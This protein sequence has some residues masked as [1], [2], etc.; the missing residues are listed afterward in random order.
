MSG[1]EGLV[2]QL[3]A[4]EI[5]HAKVGAFDIDGLLRGKYISLDKLRSALGGG[6]GFCDVIFG[7][8]IVDA[9]YDKAS[10]TGWHRG[11]PDVQAVLDPETVRDVPWE[12]GVAL[13]LADL[14]A[15]DGS[16]HPACPR[17]LLKTIRDRARA[18]G[19]EALFS[20]EFEFFMFKESPHTLQDKDFRGLTPLSPGMFGYS[21]VRS[22]QHSELMTDILAC[23]DAF[24]IEIEGLHT[25]TGPGVYE[26]AIA[27]D[28]VLRA[29]D[30]AALFKVAMKQIAHRHGLS[31]TFMAKWNQQLPGA[32]GH[33]HQSL[34]K[35][36]ENAFYGGG[37]ISETMRHYVG[38]Q[39]ELMAELTAMASPT[40]NSYKRYVPGVWAPLTV[41][42]GVDNRTSALRLIGLDSSKACRIESRQTAA[43][44][45]PYIAMA[46]SLGAGLYGIENAV[47]PPAETKG[48]ATEQ[49]APLPR[50]LKE[51]TALLEQSERARAIFGD[52]FVSHYA[53]TRR[54]EVR[55]YERAVTDWEL[56]RYFE[57][58]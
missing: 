51:A 44:L 13:I 29:A 26:A 23:M 37:E 12:P 55:E 33:L 15:D 4:R 24:D 38:G 32:S 47:E 57:A 42:W 48:D 14:R 54:W 11:F 16:P 3:R 43:D 9:L 5:K 34:L 28:E 18:L 31:V 49:G 39:C 41:G 56:R 45:N 53:H 25:E 22:G 52:V 7:W 19:Y 20:C 50:T 58:I 8:D 46:A 1:A 27:Y 35:D 2:E 17:S 10:V 36:G 40:V 30:K 21:V 6:F